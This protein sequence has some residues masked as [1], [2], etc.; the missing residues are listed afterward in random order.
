MPTDSARLQ[1]WQQIYYTRVCYRC[2]RGHRIVRTA[3]C[4]C[5]CFI[6]VAVLLRSRGRQPTVAL[7]PNACNGNGHLHQVTRDAATE[8]YSLRAAVVWHPLIVWHGRLYLYG[9]CCR[10]PC[11]TCVIARQASSLSRTQTGK[12]SSN[13]IIPWIP[14]SCK[15]NQSAAMADGWPCTAMRQ[16]RRGPCVGGSML[17][18]CAGHA[19]VT[20]MMPARG[21]TRMRTDAGVG[22]RGVCPAFP[23]HRKHVIPSAWGPAGCG[24]GRLAG[25]DAMKS[26]CNRPGQ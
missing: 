17:G 19:C 4:C 9:W 10:G 21:A 1:R 7:H 11:V 3:C 14:I 16:V 23:C 12:S 13:T 25:W 26:N 8:W 20:D 6:I 2:T 22:G 5:F 15:P 24:C 18:W